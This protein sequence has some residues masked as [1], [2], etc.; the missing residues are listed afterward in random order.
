M[1][2]NKR[3]NVAAGLLFKNKMKKQVAVVQKSCPEASKI[4][5]ITGIVAAVQVMQKFDTELAKVE[6]EVKK[7]KQKDQGLTSL[8]SEWQNTSK[9]YMADLKARQKVLVAQKEAAKKAALADEKANN[10]EADKLFAKIVDHVT[11]VK[12]K[13]AGYKSIVDKCAKAATGVPDDQKEKVEKTI[14]NAL[15]KAAPPVLKDMKKET[16]SAVK[17]WRTSGVALT[18]EQEKKLKFWFAKGGPVSKMMSPIA[19][20]VKQIQGGKLDIKGISTAMNQR[21]GL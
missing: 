7:K 5:D 15:W 2:D 14:T 8:I 10:K 21:S 20:T 6:G 19:D 11:V 12:S 16:D 17:L 3:W 9:K 13:H 4:D 1:F 18:S